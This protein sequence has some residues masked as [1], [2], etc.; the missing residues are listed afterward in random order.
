MNVGQVR[1]R[2]KDLER[3]RQDFLNDQVHGVW[4]LFDIGNVVWSNQGLWLGGW[5]VRRL[6]G[7]VFGRLGVQEVGCFGGV[8]SDKL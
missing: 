8:G 1:K 5:V 3:T 6:G 4:V 2:K 7:L